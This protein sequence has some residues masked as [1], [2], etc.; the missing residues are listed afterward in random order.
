MDNYLFQLVK[1]RKGAAPTPHFRLVR[2]LD[3]AAGLVVQQ[4]NLFPVHPSYDALMNLELARDLKESVCRVADVPLTE[5]GARY[6]SIPTTPYE[7]PDG[8]IIDLG[9][10]RFM[11]PE[12]LY[13]ALGDAVEDGD[14]SGGQRD[15]DTAGLPASRTDSIPR[16]ALDC[17]LRCES[18][19]QANLLSSVVVTG[20]G[21]CFEGMPERFRS[22]LERLA[23]SKV[24]VIAAGTGERGICAWLGGSILGSLG[25]FHEMWFTK[26]EYDEFG[27]Q[28]VD[29]KCP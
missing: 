29:R 1:R 15:L 24:K 14:V 13:T 20:G 17:A 26:A 10:E 27:P 16:I 21:S 19:A 11:V 12:L 8:T 28:L 22:E 4:R 5:A 23:G 6:S 9:L 25:S 2:T 18:D 7:L 3:P